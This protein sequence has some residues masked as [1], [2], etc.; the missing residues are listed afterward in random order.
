[1]HV[2]IWLEKCY[3]AYIMQ[4]KIKYVLVDCYVRIC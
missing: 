4:V 2:H 1:M 3:F